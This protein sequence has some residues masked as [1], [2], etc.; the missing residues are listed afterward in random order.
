M[1]YSFVNLASIIVLLIL[2]TGCT[3]EIDFNLLKG[4]LKGV[5][6]SNGG[7]SDIP[8]Q[9]MLE[10]HN[11]SKTTTS[12]YYGK[13][14]FTGVNTGTYNLKFTKEGFG[15][16]YLYGF[17]FIGGDSVTET[18]PSVNLAHLPDASISELTLNMTIETIQNE[19]YTL[20][21]KN[22][23]WSAVIKGSAPNLMAYLS[24]DAN[25]SYNNYKQHYFAQ[26]GFN[27]I[28]LNDFDTLVYKKN[29]KIYMV[30][31]PFEMLGSTYMDMNTGCRIY[32][33]I[34]TKGASNIASVIVK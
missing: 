5:V 20:I 9:V 17:P 14:S 19:Y 10:G 16:H 18:V 11:Y 32:S 30:I 28:T 31:Y 1:K 26:Q 15:T 3:I 4:N 2:E 13:Y 22:I 6:Y 8:V 23:N 12:D 33:G 7:Y 24:S 27:T 21:Q 25:V 29:T 34:Q